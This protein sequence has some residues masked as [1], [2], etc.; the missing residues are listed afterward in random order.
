MRKN[1]I[2]VILIPLSLFV[3]AWIGFSIYHNIVTSTISEPLSVQI[4]PITPTFDTKT[5]DSLKTREVASPLYSL[6]APA[7]NTTITIASPSA[8]SPLIING[9]NNV[10]QATAGGSLT[11]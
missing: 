6:S 3:L 1:D 8:C 11:Q 2:L 7:Q 9:L 4:T 5:I 10:N